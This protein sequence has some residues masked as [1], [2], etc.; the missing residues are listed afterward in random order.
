MK[1]NFSPSVDA[2][3]VY[4]NKVVIVTGHTGFKG[5]WLSLW[6]H[7][8]GAI[9]YGVSDSSISEPSHTTLLGATHFAATYTMDLCEPEAFAKIFSQIEPDFVFHLAAQAIVKTAYEQPILTWNSNVMASISILE[10]ARHFNQKKCNFVMITSDK[11]YENVEW[12]WGYRETDALGGS[13]PYSAS[14]AAAELA[15]SSYFRSFF[16]KDPNIRLATARAGNVIGGGDWAANRIVPDCIRAW[17]NNHPVTLRSPNST[18]PWQHVLEPLGGYLT[19]GASL[20]RNQFRDHE[21]FNFGPNSNQNV[22]VGDLV[23]NIAR[24][25]GKEDKITFEEEPSSMQEAGLLKLSCDKA[26]YHLG[27]QAI[28]TARETSSLTSDWY[29]EYWDP[30]A[31]ILRLSLRQIDYYQQKWI[32]RSH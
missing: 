18:R 27:W 31:D 29:R 16:S 30:D 9:V 2:L 28:L 26:L 1:Q 14:K 25:L 21:A 22:T 6:L 4:K 23:T 8:C 20:D 11:C 13:D 19:L 10:A 12:E 24:D 3:S 5:S 32:E 7:R 15:I 17:E